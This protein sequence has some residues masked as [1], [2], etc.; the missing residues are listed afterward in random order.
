MKKHS[1]CFQA[2]GF[3]NI[4]T[5]T[6]YSGVLPTENIE[7]LKSMRHLDLKRNWLSGTLPPEV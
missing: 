5:H 4:S 2:I 7:R 3:K 6:S 1:V